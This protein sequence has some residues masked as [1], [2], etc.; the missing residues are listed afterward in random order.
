[1]MRILQQARAKR[2]HNDEGF[3]LIEQIVVVGV[4]GI[5]LIIV[6]GFLM[7][8]TE[9]TTRADANVRAEQ[10]AINALR[11][12]TEDLRSAALVSPCAGFTYDK[13][14]TIEISK[15]TFGGAACP[16]RVLRYW[17]EGTNFRQSLTDYA[18]DCATVTK[19]GTRTLIGGIQSTSIFTFYAADGVTP[20]NLGTQASLVAK[21]PAIKVALSV[22]YRNNAAPL[23][24][25][26]FAS[27]RNN[28]MK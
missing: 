8:A 17:V 16:K 14:V 7:N 18:A 12:A 15:V 26:S 28:R 6:F 23:N 9:T 10:D 27:L 13:C 21:T 25:S 3:S 20:L 22:K 11:T 2:D 1:M 4:L 5:V 24:L 19:S